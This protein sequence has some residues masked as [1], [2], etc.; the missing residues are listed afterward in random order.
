M[1]LTKRDRKIRSNSGK[2]FPKSVERGAISSAQFAE[3]I[4]EA[5][6]R[7]FGQAHAAVK[8]IAA[9]TGANERAVKNWVYA[10]NGPSG[11]FLVALIRHSEE[12]LESILLLS[13]RSELVRAKKLVDARQKLGE[14]LALIDEIQRE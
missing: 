11:E 13:G 6:H 2:A 3:A 9:L 4:A 14:M 12:V 10:K 8:K 5:L 7:E 1:S